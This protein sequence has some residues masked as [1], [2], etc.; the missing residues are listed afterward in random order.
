MRGP[1]GVMTVSTGVLPKAAARC[2]AG[3]M[4]AS[5]RALTASSV[6]GFSR[7]STVPPPGSATVCPSF[8]LTA[9]I[10]CAGSPYRLA[11]DGGMKRVCPSP[12]GASR[13]RVVSPA[14]PSRATWSAR[15]LSAAFVRSVVA[16]FRS[17]AV[18]LWLGA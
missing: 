17:T 3:S 15:A 2:A 4:P 13:V 9:P 10:C 7:P 12:T 8:A 5:T 11:T 14:C 1:C 18:R 16:L 6:R